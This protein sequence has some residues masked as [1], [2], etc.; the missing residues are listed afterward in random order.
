MLDFYL[1]IGKSNRNGCKTPDKSF[2][3][4]SG[5]QPPFKKQNVSLNL[6][7]EHNHE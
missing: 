7:N 3:I 2:K 5:K 6:K 4:L 1:Y